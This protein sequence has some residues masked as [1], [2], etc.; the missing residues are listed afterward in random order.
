[1]T[2]GR[3]IIL[4]LG[5]TAAGKTALALDLAR[6]LPGGGGECVCADSM[7]V[8]RGMDLGTA[9]PTPAQREEVPHHLLDLLDSSEDGFSVDRWLDLAERAIGQIRGRRRYPIVVGGTS[10]YVQALLEGLCDGPAPVPGLR[11]RLQAADPATVRRRLETVDPAA[12]GRIHPHDRKRAIRAVEVFEVT[13]RPLS[14][15][16]RQWS[17]GSARRDVRIIGLEYAVEAINARINARVRAMM[18]GGLLDE[19]R[20]LQSAGG[21]GRQASE[22]LGYRQLLD[23]LEG[24]CSLEEA[25]EQIKIRTRR[26]AKQQ[27]TWLRRFRSHPEAVWF[28]A[29]SLSPQELVQKS[30]SA[31]LEGQGGPRAAPGRASGGPAGPEAVS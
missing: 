15:M 27:R 18:E 17:P 28:R 6:R 4:I 16:Q 12:A 8:Y 1:V 13:G 22:A 26:F 19:V 7:Q 24:R 23:Q 25:V 14:E 20:R 21:F 9:K 2:P 31:I 30:L 29:E 5:P 11:D 3:P 10:L